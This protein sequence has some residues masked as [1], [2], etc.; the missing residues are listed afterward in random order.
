M[1]TSAETKSAEDLLFSHYL[2]TGV[3][4]NGEAARVFLETKAREVAHASVQKSAESLLFAHYLRTGEQLHGEAAARF[5]ERK[6]NQWH[7]RENG[8]FA[9]AGEGVNYSGVADRAGPA[10]RARQSNTSAPNSRTTLPRG[11]SP[12][13][14]EINREIVVY[15]DKVTSSN[16]HDKAGI[17]PTGTDCTK[18]SATDST[19]CA[20]EAPTAARRLYAVDTSWIASGA[21]VSDKIGRGDY[22]SAL[23]ESHVG[24]AGCFDSQYDK[25]CPYV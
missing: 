20:F 7:L 19:A 25:V 15:G 17:D 11:T 5:V 6:F 14:P 18:S 1:S 3:R 13:A 4:L 9:R 8:Q 16:A 21:C 2:R 12:N 22:R 24:A 23:R 10:T